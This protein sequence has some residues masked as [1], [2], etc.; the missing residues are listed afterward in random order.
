MFNNNVYNIKKKIIIN[1]PFVIWNPTSSFYI[2][3]ASGT[4]NEK[5]KIISY[6]YGG[7]KVEI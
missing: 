4:Q 1:N 6:L 2:F 5:N 3:L 7:G